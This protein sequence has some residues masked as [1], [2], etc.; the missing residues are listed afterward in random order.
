MPFLKAYKPLYKG[1]VQFRSDMTRSE[2][3]TSTNAG[4]SKVTEGRLAPLP[5]GKKHSKG[6]SYKPSKPP[7]R[8]E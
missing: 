3:G 2:H 6:N 7:E 4:R 8:R 5:G 1:H